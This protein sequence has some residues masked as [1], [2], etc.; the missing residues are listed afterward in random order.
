MET[1]AIEEFGEGSYEARDKGVPTLNV[2]Y[3]P[4]KISPKFPGTVRQLMMKKIRDQFMH[5][6]YQT[7]VTKPLVIDDIIDNCTR[8]VLLEIVF[9]KTRSHVKGRHLP[10]SHCGGMLRFAAATSSP[11]DT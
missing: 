6:Q 10:F 5:P 7:D 8:E 1:A 4:Q 2:S 3:K 11:L 9:A